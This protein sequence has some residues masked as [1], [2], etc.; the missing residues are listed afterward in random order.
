MILF[1][2]LLCTI[3]IYIYRCPS[4]MRSQGAMPTAYAKLAKT[5]CTPYGIRVSRAAAAALA[6]VAAGST[7]FFAVVV[8]S[9]IAHKLNCGQLRRS[10]ASLAQNMEIATCC[11]HVKS[12]NSSARERS[13]TFMTMNSA[14]S[15][16]GKRKGEGSGLPTNVA[17]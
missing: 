17:N 1:L 7:L 3:S 14:Q 2:I 6:A 13:Q 9:Q 11:R 8:H 5:L 4:L 16:R 12:G 10:A 15:E